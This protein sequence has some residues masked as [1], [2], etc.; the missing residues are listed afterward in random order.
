M[1]PENDDMRFEICTA[2]NY[3]CSICPQDKFIRPR[4]V[5]SSELFTQLLD[6]IG[7]ATGQYT[8][9]TFAGMGEP[10]LDPDFLAKV[11]VARKRGYSVRLLTNG[12]R[13]T[14]ELFKEL[15]ALGVES[16]RV[17]L[18]GIDRESYN[19]VHNP[20]VGETF[21]TVMRNLEA[22]CAMPRKTKVLLTYNI[23]SGANDAGMQAWIEHWEPRANL[24]EVWK[25][26]NW[27]YGRDLRQLSQA[28]RPT[29]GRPFTGP[30]QVQVDGTVNMCC[31]DFNGDLTL[32]DL[33]TQ[34]LDEVFRSPLFKKIVA[35]HSSGDYEDSGLICK[36]CDQ[37]NADKT[38]VMV[39]NSGFDIKQRVEMIS[40]TYRELGKHGDRDA[41]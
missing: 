25:P 5:M 29:C 35:C 28:K 30:L 36:D 31:F 39:Y 20:K 7:A 24:V 22:I 9:L 40:T 26:H 14:T 16:V 13:L 12:S 11:R 10:L 2:C 38:D 6:R 18:Y 27:V 1:I 21:D 33:K 19:K 4:S 37:R 34:D 8:N 3:N 41:K 23:V 32:G 17:S 15:D